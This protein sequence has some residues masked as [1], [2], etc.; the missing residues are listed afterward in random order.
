MIFAL[1]SSK[2]RSKVASL[3]ILILLCL[4]V[5]AE[6]RSLVKSCPLDKHPTHH[7][8]TVDVGLHAAGDISE[9]ARPYT[10]NPSW[11]FVN[12]VIGP[13]SLILLLTVPVR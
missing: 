13:S 7:A 4:A 2:Q 9:L 6:R 11:I 12:D 8:I 3:P 5:A 10:D 1:K